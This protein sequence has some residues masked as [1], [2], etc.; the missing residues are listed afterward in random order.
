MSVVLPCRFNVIL[1]VKFV[2]S[3]ARTMIK[4]CHGFFLKFHKHLHITSMM[5]TNELYQLASVAFCL[6]VAWVWPLHFTEVCLFGHS[7]QSCF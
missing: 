1:D 3:N 7:Y 6:V 2:R 4:D 5:Q